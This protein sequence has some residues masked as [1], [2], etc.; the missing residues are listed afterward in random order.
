MN[1]IEKNIQFRLANTKDINQIMRFIKLY[2]KRNHLCGTNKK[3]FK[4]EYCHNNKVNFIMAINKKNKKI[5]ALQGFIP[6]SENKKNLHI[7][8]SIILVKP[9]LKFPFLGVE[10]MKNMIKK[11]QAKTYCG[12][13]TNPLNMIPLVE[14]FFNRYTSKMIHHYFLNQ[15]IKNFKIAKIRKKTMLRFNSKK[16]SY[17]KISSFDEIKNKLKFNEFKNHLP[18][19]SELYIRRRYFNNITLFR[20]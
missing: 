7:C 20:L 8:G 14:K 1:L 15:K 3:I 11:T 13:G 17:K 18:F 5:N 10:T 4:Y 16:L 6:Y 2:W 9:G 12:I 19:K